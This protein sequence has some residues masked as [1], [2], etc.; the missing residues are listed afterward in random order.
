MQGK[1]KETFV[2]LD[3]E[4]TPFWRAEMLKDIYISRFSIAERM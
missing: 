1:G 3:M 4:V 2:H